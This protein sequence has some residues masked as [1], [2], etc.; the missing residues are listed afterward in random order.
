MGIGR[1]VIKPSKD[2]LVLPNEKLLFFLSSKCGSTSV[3][4]MALH[5]LDYMDKSDDFGWGLQYLNNVGRL[6]EYEDY[7]KVVIT[8][9][10]WDRLVALYFDRV[11]RVMSKGFHRMGI[12]PNFSFREFALVVCRTEVAIVD[13]H[14]W[15]QTIYMA[16]LPEV[17]IDIDSIGPGWA[18]LAKM[19]NERNGVTIPHVLP[20]WN[21]HPHG[22]QRKGF[23]SYYDHDIVDA[24]QERYK[25]DVELL[26]YTFAEKGL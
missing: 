15:P 16:A 10:P 1:Q 18:K 25:R 24:V 21:K 2:I 19:V 5:K 4:R 11:K 26:G 6:G 3:R 13:R 12:K 22:R 8:R 14:L 7:I 20:H 17:V 9:N 23:R